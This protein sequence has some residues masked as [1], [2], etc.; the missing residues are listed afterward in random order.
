LNA[1]VKATFKY[2]ITDREGIHMPQCSCLQ[3]FWICSVT[4]FSQFGYFVLPSHN[5]CKLFVF[6]L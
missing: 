4:S 3:V 2:K 5:T 1:E 6:Y